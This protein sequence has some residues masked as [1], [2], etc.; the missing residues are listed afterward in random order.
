MLS[1]II[2]NISFV[3]FVEKMTAANVI[4]VK[5]ININVIFHSI[6]HY[7]RLIE[8]L[9]VKKQNNIPILYQMHVNLGRLIFHQPLNNITIIMFTRLR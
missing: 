7:M 3:C 9:I 6:I 2:H 1:K 4:R 8:L 5:S